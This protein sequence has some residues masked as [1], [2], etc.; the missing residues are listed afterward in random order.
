MM[1][2]KKTMLLVCAF[3]MTVFL[4]ATNAGAHTWGGYQRDECEAQAPLLETCT[5]GAHFRFHDD[6]T[7]RHGVIG[8][9]GGDFT[10]SIESRLVYQGGERN[11]QCDFEDGSTVPGSCT[12]SGEFPPPQTYFVHICEASGT[13]EWGCFVEHGP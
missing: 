11:F 9:V 1:Y 6:S 12:G 13:G 2:K 5:T 7:F 3:V 10:G 8:S 4:T